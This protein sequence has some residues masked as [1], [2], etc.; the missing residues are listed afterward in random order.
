[1]KSQLDKLT[2]QVPLVLKRKCRTLSFGYNPWFAST[3]RSNRK[4]LKSELNVL[5]RSHTF[6]KAPNYMLEFFF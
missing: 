6:Y 1:M 4:K 5:V 3:L 2:C